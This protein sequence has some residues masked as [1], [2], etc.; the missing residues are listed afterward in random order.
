MQTKEINNLKDEIE[1][2]LKDNNYHTYMTGKWHLGYQEN[3]SPMARGFEQSYAL[4][5]PVEPVTLIICY[6]YLDL[7]KPLTGK[8]PRYLNRFQMIFILRN[9]IQIK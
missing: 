1:N 7:I 2:I 3:N 9:F 6:Q 8:M 5:Y 4:S